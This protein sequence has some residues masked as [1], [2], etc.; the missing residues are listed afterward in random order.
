[1]VDLTKSHWSELP[2][3]AIRQVLAHAMSENTAFLDVTTGLSANEPILYLSQMWEE[4]SAMALLGE[5]VVPCEIGIFM[6]TVAI[7]PPHPPLLPLFLSNVVPRL[8][9][10]SPHPLDINRCA[11]LASIISSSLLITRYHEGLMFSSVHLARS[12]LKRLSLMK[13][14]EAA[15]LYRQIT[16]TP[17][18]ILQFTMT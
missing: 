3:I 1:M 5:L 6:L 2:R 16:H 15:I 18:F 12:F 8:V 14:S 7:P 17:S 4:L 13:S 10:G 9:S 11:L